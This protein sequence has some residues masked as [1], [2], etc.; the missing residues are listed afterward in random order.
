MSWKDK[1]KENQG[2][3]TTPKLGAKAIQVK[4]TEDGEVMFATWDSENSTNIYQKTITGVIVGQANKLSAFCPDL[5][6]NGG[7]YQSGYYYSNENISVWGQGKP[8]YTGNFEG[9][10]LALNSANADKP[11]KKKVLFVQT[12]EGMLALENNMVIG[13]DKLRQFQG[14]LSENVFKFTAK[15]YDPKNPGIAPKS[16]EYLGKFANKN[17]PLYFDLEVDELITDDIA[18]MLDLEKAL[19]TYAEWKK[20]KMKGGEDVVEESAKAE[21]VNEEFEELDDDDLPF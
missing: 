12:A 18:D 7:Q 9:L 21:K 17:H 13:I 11:S 15:E 2:G 20:F 6:K 3:S 1:I 14:E 5:G 16:V 10:L 4:R 8:F 19:D